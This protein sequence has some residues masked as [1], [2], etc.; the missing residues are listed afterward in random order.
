MKK[1]KNRIMVWTSE[2]CTEIGAAWEG[3]YEHGM[4][5]TLIEPEECL[6]ILLATIKPQDK[7]QACH[8]GCQDKQPYVC[9]AITV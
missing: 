6:N 8:I 4:P 7:G 3:G 5:L 9:P 2:Q 1:L